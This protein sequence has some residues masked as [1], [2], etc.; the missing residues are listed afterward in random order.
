MSQLNREHPEPVIRGHGERVPDVAE[1]WYASV[2]ARLR[3]S[4]GHR[5]YREIA[6]RTGTHAETV[7]RYFDDG[8][9]CARFLARLS[10]SYGLSLEWLL[11]GNGE[12]HIRSTRQKPRAVALAVD[13]ATGDLEVKA[14]TE[15]HGAEPAAH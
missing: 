1:A 2:R 4:V 10:E 12:V 15:G 9:P 14:G 7:R 3:E 11:L 5:T 13:L 8:K 6:D